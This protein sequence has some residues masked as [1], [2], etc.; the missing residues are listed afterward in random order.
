M[1]LQPS[2]DQIR[3]AMQ[4]GIDLQ[5]KLDTVAH[6]AVLDRESALV[7]ACALLRNAVYGVLPPPYPNWGMGGGSHMEHEAQRRWE[8]RHGVDA[9][10]VRITRD[11][12]ERLFKLLNN[13]PERVTARGVELARLNAELKAGRL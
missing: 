13:L 10:H 2:E 5:R 8:I 3:E 9:D 12:V 7:E 11:G 1:S 6:Q 4:A